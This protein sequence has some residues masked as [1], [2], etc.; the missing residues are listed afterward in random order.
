MRMFESSPLRFIMSW[1]TVK[2]FLRLN[3]TDAS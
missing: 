1:D 3:I 2:E